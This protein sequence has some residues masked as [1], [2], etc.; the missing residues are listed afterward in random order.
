MDTIDWESESTDIFVN[1]KIPEDQR[2]RLEKRLRGFAIKGH[3]WLSTS[4][5]SSHSNISPKWVA[6][7]KQAVLTSAAS[8]NRHLQVTETDR[9]IHTLPYFHVGGLGIYARAY[10]SRSKV[11]KCSPKWNPKNFQMYCHEYSGT[12]TALVPT[13]LYD[14]VQLNLQAPT[15]LRATVIGGGALSD[16]LYQKG[17]Q[18]GWKPLPSYGLSECASQV[19][20]AALDSLRL[21]VLPQLQV[22]SHIDDLRITEEGCLTIRSSSL[23]STYAIIVDN[24]C[25][26]EDPKDNGWFETE[27]LASIQ[28][29]YLTIHGRKTDIVKVGG[30][31]VN[32]EL[33]NRLLINLCSSLSTDG[34]QV[35]VA[36]PSERLGHEVHIAECQTTP[37]QLSS[38][39][40]CFN[41]R[42]LP[43]ERIK[44]VHHL[45]EIP[46]TE[47]SKIKKQ[48][49]INKCLK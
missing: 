24:E 47:L 21:D 5:S 41:S 35:L 28:G 37:E 49:L 46:R 23:L 6:L 32:I 30:E 3:I 14:L 12:L 16:E 19:A 18:L 31:N 22:L 9:W 45:E 2:Y 38:L 40:N 33:L 15:S 17:K 29:G 43:F 8:V 4:G 11:L 48:I 20:T 27:D 44:S 26:S 7:S 36:L 42:V 25:L 39:I 34:E 1:P 13:Q 10:L